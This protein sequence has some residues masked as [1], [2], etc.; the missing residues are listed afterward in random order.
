VITL[1]GLSSLRR[2]EIDRCKLHENSVNEILSRAD[3]SDPTSRVDEV[4]STDIPHT[5]IYDVLVS[6]AEQSVSGQPSTTVG[7]GNADNIAR[8]NLRGQEV[9]KATGEEQEAE[10][11]H[12]PPPVRR[13]SRRSGR[14]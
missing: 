8:A 11:E 5:A 4:D 7:D 10:P 12:A 6:I 2:L 14:S 9:N 1:L 13:S 3:A